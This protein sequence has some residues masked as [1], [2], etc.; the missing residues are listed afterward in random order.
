MTKKTKPT[1][2]T[3]IMMKITKRKTSMMKKTKKPDDT[4]EKYVAKNERRN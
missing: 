4:E 2:M 3:K 1:S